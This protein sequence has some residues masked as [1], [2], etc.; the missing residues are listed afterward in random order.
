MIALGIIILILLLIFLLPV[1]VD[2]AYIDSVFTLKAKLGPFNI[3]IVPGKEKAAE[4]KEKKPKKEKKKKKAVD[5]KTEPS[6][7]TKKK[8]KLSFD[9]VIT[10]IRIALRAL[11]R[12]RRSISVDK[13]ML[14]ILTAGPDPYSTVM[15]Y[16]YFNAAVGALR[17]LLHKAFRI[18]DEDYASA[19][20]FEGDKLKVDGRIVLTVRIGEILLLVLCAV[21]ALI[22]WFLGVR[23]RNKA[24]AKAQAKE[25]DIKTTNGK[26]T[27]NSSAEKGN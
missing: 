26:I 13:L 24:L 12:F 6:K 11:G 4:E 5:A 15:N 21:F 16:G 20:D 14:H 25:L 27:E 3:G 19:I 18:K 7:K 23:R 2:A 9:D 8:L 10:I 22:R 17:P 1:G